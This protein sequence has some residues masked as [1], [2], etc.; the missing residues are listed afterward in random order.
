MSLR[1]CRT[2]PCPSAIAPHLPQQPVVPDRSSRGVAHYR[3][4]IA[5]RRELS[6]VGRGRCHELLVDGHHSL[7]LPAKCVCLDQHGRVSFLALRNRNNVDELVY[8]Q[9]S[10]GG[11]VEEVID[12]GGFQHSGGSLALVVDGG[13]PCAIYRKDSE[14]SVRGN[15]QFDLCLAHCIP[16]GTWRKERTGVIGNLG[17]YPCPV[18]CDGCLTQIVH[19]QEGGYFIRETSRDGNGWTDTPPL[20]RQ[21]DGTA[22]QS[23][24]TRQGTTLFSFSSRRGGGAA[25]ST[26]LGWFENGRWQRELVDPAA[27][28]ILS[29]TLLPD[30]SPIVLVRRDDGYALVRRSGQDEWA[31]KP[32]PG[33]TLFAESLTCD[34]QGCLRL[35]GQRAERRQLVLYELRD[36][37]WSATNVDSDIDSPDGSAGMRLTEG[38]DTT[39]FATIRDKNRSRVRVYRKR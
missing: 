24:A 5:D 32:V 2:S 1:S 16:N 23:Y 31:S 39:I 38:G 34:E 28:A 10:N 13:E 21:G 9:E 15:F 33:R 8:Y 17:R 37:N 18:M 3:A 30:D 14:L 11:V 26:F 27:V 12:T 19:Y 35:L 25:V 6:Q 22:L 36:G 7:A 20:G 4:A 29:A